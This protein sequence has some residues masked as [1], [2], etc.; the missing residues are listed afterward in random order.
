MP[1]ILVLNGFIHRLKSPMHIRLL[2]GI[3]TFYKV[4][5]RLV[6]GP[7][8]SPD[9]I[10]VD[11][12]GRVE[13]SLRISF[14]HLSLS[15]PSWRPNA[16]ITCF[17]PKPSLNFRHQISLFL[18]LRLQFIDN[19]NCITLGHLYP[20]WCLLGLLLM[21]YVEIISRQVKVILISWSHRIVL[22]PFA[23]TIWGLWHWRI[24]RLT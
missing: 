22:L 3:L 20:W 16:I 11:I 17:H 9:Y 8:R 24:L 10:L 6:T 14:L 12:G 19:V 21:I 15:I 5:L 2:L 13:K 18:K 23:I 7:L 1:L 4:I